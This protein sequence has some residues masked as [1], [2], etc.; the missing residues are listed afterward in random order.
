MKLGSVLK[1]TMTTDNWDTL[2]S[3]CANIT[4]QHV[5]VFSTHFTHQSSHKKPSNIEQ[6]RNA[7]YLLKP[8]LH[9]FTA[10]VV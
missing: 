10:I 9:H 2:E 8:A 4:M 5:L 6:D 3:L 1:K 7:R